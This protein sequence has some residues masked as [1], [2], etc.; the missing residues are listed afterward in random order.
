MA[1]G[2][3]IVM[4]GEG[5][6]TIVPLLR[7]IEESRRS[8]ADSLADDCLAGIPNLVYRE[9]F[10]GICRTM[11]QKQSVDLDLLPIMDRNLFD[12]SLYDH[13]TILTSRC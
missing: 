10:G 1:Y 12:L 3:D 7:C 4:L 9:A 5:E 11:A 6:L 13:H 2:A 8:K